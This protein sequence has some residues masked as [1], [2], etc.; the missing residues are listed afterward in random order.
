MKI[1]CEI[2]LFSTCTFKDSPSSFSFTAS[3]PSLLKGMGKKGT[4]LLPRSILEVFH[5]FDGFLRRE[6]VCILQQTPDPGVHC[7]SFGLL[8][9]SSE[10]PWTT[11]LG[12]A[13]RR[14]FEEHTTKFPT[15]SFLPFK[16]LLPACSQRGCHGSHPIK[17]SH[18]H[19][20]SVPS[21]SCSPVSQR[22]KVQGFLPQPEQLFH[23]FLRRKRS[24]LLSWAWRCLWRKMTFANIHH[25]HRLNV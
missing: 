23:S 24:S 4:T 9:S 22:M 15:T 14:L 18:L 2:L 13:I 19:H 17:G 21:A 7:V 1:S 3:T 20:H 25:S 5:P 8:C 16:A 11:F 6:M 12:A 10:G